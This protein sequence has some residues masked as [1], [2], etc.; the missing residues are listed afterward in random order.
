M[1]S[2]LETTPAPFGAPAEDLGGQPSA[3]EGLQRGGDL[4]G[5]LGRCGGTEGEPWVERFVLLVSSG[6]EIMGQ[7]PKPFCFGA[8]K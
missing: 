6:A 7:I 8:R 1:P 3:A 5:A 2:P 4:D